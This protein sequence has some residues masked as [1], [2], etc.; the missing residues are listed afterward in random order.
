MFR[1]H[2]MSLLAAGLFSV[3]LYVF[4]AYD[5]LSAETTLALKVHLPLQLSVLKMT[6]LHFQALLDRLLLVLLYPTPLPFTRRHFLPQI[7]LLEAEVRTPLGADP[8]V[9]AV[10]AVAVDLRALLILNTPSS[11]ASLFKWRALA[12]T[13]PR[14]LHWANLLK[15]ISF[16]VRLFC[17]E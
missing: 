9:E 14:S 7:H 5:V 16:F 1:A 17:H 12:L 2:Q 15:V 3:H 10:A 13:L 11:L 4:S 6:G 8:V